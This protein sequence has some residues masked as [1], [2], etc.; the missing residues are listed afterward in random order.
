MTDSEACLIDV[1]KMTDK[2][3]Q[4]LTK[5]QKQLIQ[6]YENSLGNVSVAVRACNLSRETFY[7]WKRENPLFA[8]KIEEIDEASIDFAE[9]MLKKNIRDGKESS[10][11]FYLKTKGKSRG[12]IETVENEIK[13]NQF[14][15]LMQELPDDE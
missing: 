3:S 10:I 5:S 15:K 4:R 7:R 1:T 13:I 11:F 9:T 12:Y 2:K 8:E 6:A 14:E